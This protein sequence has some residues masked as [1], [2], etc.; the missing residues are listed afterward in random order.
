[1]P[2]TAALFVREEAAVLMTA[3]AAARP[4]SD[5]GKALTLFCCTVRWCGLQQE[6]FRS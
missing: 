3:A 6:R 4:G 1:V 5:E 2:D